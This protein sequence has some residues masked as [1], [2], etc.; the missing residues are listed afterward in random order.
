MLCIKKILRDYLL[1]KSEQCWAVLGRQ[2]EWDKE[3]GQSHKIDILG[4]PWQPSESS[5]SRLI[6]S[7]VSGTG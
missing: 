2:G 3:N 4:S 6:G 7:W 5:F 1:K